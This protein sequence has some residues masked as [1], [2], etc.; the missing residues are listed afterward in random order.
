MSRG[1]GG[2]GGNKFYVASEDELSETERKLREFE[3]A[4]KLVVASEEN[5]ELQE[6]VEVKR[7]EEWL[8]TKLQEKSNLDK[9]FEEKMK[10]APHYGSIPT[11][12]R[13]DVETYVKSGRDINKLDLRK[14]T[15]TAVMFSDNSKAK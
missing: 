6:K 12:S 15:A 9:Y 14:P 3:L 1:K 11:D 8:K 4:R 7:R 13:I 10:E 5:K 2:I